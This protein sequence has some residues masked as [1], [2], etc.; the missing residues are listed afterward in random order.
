M[1]SMS[2]L[3]GKNQRN[4]LFF[5]LFLIGFVTIS[6]NT[7]FAGCRDDYKAIIH[8]IWQKRKNTYYEWLRLSKN[9]TNNLY[10]I[11]GSTNNLLKYAFFCNDSYML[12]ELLSLYIKSLDTLEY[13][14]MY[15][16]HYFPDNTKRNNFYRFSKK[17]Y[18][19]LNHSG[20]AGLIKG[21]EVILHSSQFLYLLAESL[22]IISSQTDREGIVPEDYVK[23]ILPVI[24]DHYKRWIFD[25]PGP[26]QVRGWGCRYNGK[27]IKTGMNHF[28][29]ITKKL[30]RE[31]GDNL[32]YCNAVTDTDMWIIAGVAHLLS[33]NKRSPD[34]I[35]LSSADRERF[36]TYLKT[37]VQ[38]LRSRITYKD[39]KDFQGDPVKGANFDLGVWDDHPDYAWIWNKSRDYPLKKIAEK[40]KHFKE[41]LKNTIY[42]VAKDTGVLPALKSLKPYIKGSENSMRPS[43]RKLSAGWD[44]SHARRFVHVFDAL[45]KNRK[46]LGLDFPD[47]ELMKR[48]ANQFLYGSFNKDFEK[49]LF[50]NF[51]DGTN[52]WYRVGYSRR[53]GFGYP[54]WGMSWAALTGGYAFWMKYN[55]DLEKLYHTL[56]QMIL[57]TDNT[58]INHL[59]E[60][61][62][63]THFYHYT[64]VQEYNFHDINNPNTQELSC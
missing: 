39:L 56:L 49:P 55:P 42:H 19:W 37:G 33:A 59:H 22:N 48:L 62:E 8:K 44:I 23:R 11:Q 25:T 64:K 35:P 2:S 36:H 1:L 10:M 31:L 52:G 27:Y 7:I 63:K 61:Y 43:T 16:L 20:K 24:V 26:F 54:P 28:E 29:F 60:F 34:L 47:L 18:M 12:K 32:S 17:H 58:K 51:M 6:V 9:D 50:S 13:T 3:T 5:V 46:L 41:T 57:S 45:Y 40:A 15:V 21:E 30:K 53:D 14:D 4:N 38:L